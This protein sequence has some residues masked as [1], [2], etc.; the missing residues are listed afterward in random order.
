VTKV[1][2]PQRRPHLTND[3][4]VKEAVL[5]PPVKLL[6]P[7]TYLLSVLLDEDAHRADAGRRLARLSLL[8]LI[9][10]LL[11]PERTFARRQFDWFVL[12]LRHGFDSSVVFH[13]ST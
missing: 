2:A 11:D 7:L 13:F 8:R 10:E 6:Q 5:R 9:L 12:A 4:E 1:T 3:G